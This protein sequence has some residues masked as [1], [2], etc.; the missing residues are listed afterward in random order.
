MVKPKNIQPLASSAYIHMA[1][2]AASGFGKT[3]FAGTAPNALFFTTDPEGT[4]SARRFG[5]TAEEWRITNWN[6]LDEA[7]RWLRDEGIESEGYQ[8]LLVDNG[9]ECQELGMA[10][11]MEQALKAKPDRSPYVPDKR[12]YQISQNGMITLVKTIH[13]LP[14]NVLWTFH[15]K[16][17]EDGEGSDFYSVAIQGKDG[18]VAEQVLGYMNIIGMGEVIEKETAGKTREI[19]RTYFTHTGPYRGKDRFGVLGRFKD[20]LTVPDLSKLISEGREGTPR[21]KTTA[22]AKRPVRRTATTRTRRA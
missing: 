21:R 19:R 5:S 4:I 13:T 20:D 15:R 9:T 14:I 1:L 10:M 16:G 7:Y 12:E 3:V 17:M 22:T 6:E 2:V 8:W 18:Q 11:A